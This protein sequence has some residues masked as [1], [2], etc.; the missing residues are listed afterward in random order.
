MAKV[1]LTVH[2]E[3]HMKSQEHLHMPLL[4]EKQSWEIKCYNITANVKK[5]KGLKPQVNET[6]YTLHCIQG[7]HKRSQRNIEFTMET[8]PKITAT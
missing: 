6:K 2:Q 3:A 4:H 5:E 8:P 7:T 1:Q